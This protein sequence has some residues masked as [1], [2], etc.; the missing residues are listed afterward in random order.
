MKKKDAQWY[1]KI[2]TLD[3]QD[4][5]W[6]E[7]T[8]REVDFIIQTLGL[9]GKERILD[10]ACG[11][12]RHALSFA[13]RGYEVVGVDI[14]PAYVEHAE[15]IAQ[16]E[17]LPAEF[18]CKD[19]REVEYAQAFD[20]VLNLADGALGYLEN[21]A[22]NLKSFDAI[23]RALKPGGKH[24]MDVCNAEHAARCFPCRNWE[25]GE[26]TLALSLF[27][28]NAETHT[29]LYT[30]CDLPY[31]Q[32]LEKPDVAY[33][34]PIRLYTPAELAGI[35]GGRG[36]KIQRTFSNYQ[37]KPAADSELQLMVYSQKLC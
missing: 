7:N 16:Q 25:L 19:I 3:I 35:L 24:F 34:D 4:Q 20:V 17:G 14:T 27:E 8:E 1:R 15:Q 10:L 36:M 11:F 13:R 6:V 18:F 21:D 30:G 12:G 31:G 23:A 32:P 29:M 37:G 33:G 5:S 28:W 2:W 26:K 9:T 22:E